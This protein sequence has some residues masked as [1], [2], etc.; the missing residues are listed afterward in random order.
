MGERNV[1]SRLDL[2]GGDEAARLARSGLGMLDG[3][4]TLVL[5]RDPKRGRKPDSLSNS[6]R[7]T[8]RASGQWH[9]VCVVL[10]PLK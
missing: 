10:P 2:R 9:A 6:I 7:L 8:S 3:V 4:K 1:H 5:A